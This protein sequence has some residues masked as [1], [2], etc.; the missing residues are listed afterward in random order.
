MT[1]GARCGACRASRSWSSFCAGVSALCGVTPSVKRCLHLIEG[2]TSGSASSAS[3]RV[4]SLAGACTHKTPRP[5]F[6][7]KRTFYTAIRMS[8]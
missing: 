8:A 5:L 6:P 1:G 2:E 3:R 4:P 7:Q